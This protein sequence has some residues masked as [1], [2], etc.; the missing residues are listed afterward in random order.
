MNTTYMEEYR[1]WMDS[2]SLSEKEWNELNSISDNEK[3]IENR[4]FAPLQFGTAGLR[5]TMKT[6]LHNM[7]IHIIRH[8]TQAFAEVIKAEGEQKMKDGVV[9]AY[10][11]RNN[12]EWFAKEAACVMAANGIFVRIFEA[13]RPTPEL[14]FAIIHYG[15]AAGLNITASHN[16]KE[17]NGYKVYWSDGAQLPPQKAAAIAER[18]EKLDVFTAYMNCDFESAVE[19][20]RIEVIG[21]ETDELFLASVLGESVNPEVVKKAAEDLKRRAEELGL[22]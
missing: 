18:M 4:F 5:G 15:A 22:I 19:T 3:E 6:G 1:R 20:G 21:G 13:L 9:I 17:Y 16:P 7:N 10:D 14:S 8:A 11:C 12:S 2:P